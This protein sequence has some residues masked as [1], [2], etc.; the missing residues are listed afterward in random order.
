MQ[1]SEVINAMFAT[2]DTQ[3]LSPLTEGVWSII[4]DMGTLAVLAAVL[5]L[6]VC[7]SPM[8]RGAKLGT[9]AIIV[10]ICFALPYIPDL[11]SSLT[12]GTATVTQNGAAT[13]EELAK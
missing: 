2:F 10:V 11:I 12:S 1:T 4:P 9:L 5:G 7:L 6:I 3:V 8:Q 13:L